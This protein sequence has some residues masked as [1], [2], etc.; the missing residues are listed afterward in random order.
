M[1]FFSSTPA[2]AIIFGYYNTQG[3]G[4]H[5]RLLLEY[6]GVTYTNK[7]IANI[8]QWK[9]EKSDL[10]S[11]FPNV[12]YLTDGEVTI[13]E[14]EAIALY[15]C[16]KKNRLEMLGRNNDEVVM[17]RAARGVINDIWDVAHREILF[18][19]NVAF[20]GKKI[21]D[22]RLHPKLKQ[23]SNYLGSN[24]FLLGDVVSYVDFHFF[25]TLCLIQ[26]IEKVLPKAPVA[27]APAQPGQAPQI[28]G[29][30]QSQMGAPA[31][32]SPYGNQLPMAQSST[33]PTGQPTT[34]VPPQPPLEEAY[35]NLGQ[36]IQRFNSI[37]QIAAYHGNPAKF[38]AKPFGFPHAILKI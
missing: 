17:L 35:Y 25:V 22:E 36:Y 3:R 15:L 6:L 13:V 19:P 24:Q 32:G 38:Q 16:Y 27:G 9:S 33:N 7:K 21:L 31:M 28:G 26:E 10:K 2:T 20:E 12:P 30:T 29:V 4:E 23:L 18:N 37:P 8:D 11:P 5:L 34:L 14:S 1:N